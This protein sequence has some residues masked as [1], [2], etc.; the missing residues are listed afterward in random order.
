M[1]L[2]LVRQT[3]CQHIHTNY[4]NKAH[5]TFNQIIIGLWLSIIETSFGKKYFDA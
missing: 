3:D 2:S 4:G 5:C 1:K